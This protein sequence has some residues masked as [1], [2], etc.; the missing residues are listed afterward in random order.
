MEIYDPR[1]RYG[2]RGLLLRAEEEP[3]NVRNMLMACPANYLWGDVRQRLDHGL[4]A[5]AALV[6]THIPSDYLGLSSFDEENCFTYVESPQWMWGMDWMLFSRWTQ[7]RWVW[8]A[9]GEAQQDPPMS[10]MNC[11]MRFLDGTR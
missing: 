1:Q 6:N 10:S 8:Q 9:T 2:V 7:T 5:G 3:S 11:K 4:H